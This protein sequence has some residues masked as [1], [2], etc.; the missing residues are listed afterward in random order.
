MS[1]VLDHLP[2]LGVCGYSGSG[3]TTLLEQMI[4]RLRARGLQVA[5]VKHDVHGIDV[6]RPGKDSDR[7]FR[8]GA[9]MVLQGADEELVRSHRQTPRGLESRLAA[10]ACEYDL[11]LVE[12][13]KTSPFSK[14][15][16][17]GDGGDGP[18]AEIENV[19]AVLGRSPDLLDSAL[20]VVEAQLDARC[21][22]APLLG[23]LLIGG[24]SRRMGRA[25]HLLTDGG[26]TWLERTVDTMRRVVTD[27]A[28]VGAGDVPE[29]LADCVRLPDVRDAC[30]PAAGLLAAMRWAPGAS[31]LVAACDLP[32]LTV[33]ALE[34]LA[35][36]RRPGVWACLPRLPG[37]GRV[38]PLLAH[39]DG[40]S[41]AALEDLVCE[42]HWKLQTLA[43]HPKIISPTVP[44]PLAPAW[45]NVNRPDQID[46]AACTTEE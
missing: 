38:E 10:M 46:P 41:R 8:A 17:L 35:A 2:I 13:H 22:A 33:E 36:Q 14:I 42:E 5:V 45:R 39:Y 32:D 37:A 15:W 20:R 1:E 12:G 44:E 30:G 31:W 9:D 23:C 27:V 40:R 19:L 6:D 34:W 43:D 21:Q 24:K 16:L 18:P 11:V 7:L 26:K 25:K 3:K 29:A 4:P 28:I